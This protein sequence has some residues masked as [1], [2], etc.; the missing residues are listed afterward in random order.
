MIFRKAFR[1]CTPALA[2]GLL[3]AAAPSLLAQNGEE[4]CSDAMFKGRY[5]YATDGTVL[6]DAVFAGP[7]PFAVVGFLYADG[8][9]HITMMQDH[10]TGI[11]GAGPLSQTTPRDLVASSVSGV[12][13]TVNPDCTG[14]ITQLFQLP[15]R[16]EPVEAPF[17]LANGGREGWAIQQAAPPWLI[18]LATFKRVDSEL[19]EKVDALSRELARIKT[20]LHH[21]A[22]RLGIIPPKD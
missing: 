3:L 19:D 14:T 22:R 17:V 4:P 21:M 1:I 11:Q 20:L 9:G 8:Q 7:G 2:V 5:A 10:F 13:Y 6:V 12:W 15:D 16:Q 18:G